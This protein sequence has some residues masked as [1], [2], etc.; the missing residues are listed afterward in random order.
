VPVALSQ[1]LFDRMCGLGQQVE[2]RVYDEG[3]THIEAA[4]PAY[5]DAMDWIDARF[6]GEPATSTCP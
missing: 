3:Q 1:L 5:A 2:R 6:A 4:P